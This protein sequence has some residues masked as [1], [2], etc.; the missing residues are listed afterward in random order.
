LAA[1]VI[2]ALARLPQTPQFTTASSADAASPKRA[3]LGGLPDDTAA[4]NGCRLMA[5]VPGGPAQRA[6]VQAGDVIVQLG[7]HNIAAFKDLLAAL[8]DYSEGQHVRLTVLRG[9]RPLTFE[10]TLASTP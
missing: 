2:T 5:V 9:G 10:I 8:Q 1:D 6:G 3:F 7:T 4:G